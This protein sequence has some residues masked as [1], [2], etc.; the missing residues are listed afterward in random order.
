MECFIPRESWDSKALFGFIRLRSPSKK[1]DPVFQC[2]RHKGLIRELHVYNW[3]VSV[4][5]AAAKG[6]TQHR[7]T[8]KKR[9]LHLAEFIA[10]AHG[11]NGTAVITGEG[12]RMVIA[13]LILS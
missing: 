10:W 1:H 4:G 7:G 6:V 8:G 12:V 13:M 9:R 5:D 2:L 11:L 3:L